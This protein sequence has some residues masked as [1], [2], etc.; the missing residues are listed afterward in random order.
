MYGVM[1]A[2]YVLDLIEVEAVLSLTPDE[3]S[4]IL[5]KYEYG[6]SSEYSK[7]E[8]QRTLDHSHMRSLSVDE[9]KAMNL[10]TYEDFVENRIVIERSLVGND[11]KPNDYNGASV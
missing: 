9:I 5:H 10:R 8:N 2:L 11:V 6:K 3:Q 4:R 1:D 7:P